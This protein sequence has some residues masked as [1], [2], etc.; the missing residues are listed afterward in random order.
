MQPSGKYLF[1]LFWR[2]EGLRY[3]AKTDFK[4]LLVTNYIIRYPFLLATV[5]FFAI[6]S[7]VFFRLWKELEVLLFKYL[8]IFL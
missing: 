7:S 6:L 2:Y 3:L 4:E 1:A 8:K 5:S